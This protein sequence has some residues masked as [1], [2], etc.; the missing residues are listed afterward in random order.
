[1]TPN[2]KAFLLVR[3]YLDNHGAA[4]GKLVIYAS[5]WLVSIRVRLLF[6]LQAESSSA[7]NGATFP[8]SEA[9]MKRNAQRYT[10]KSPGASCFFSQ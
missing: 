8:H 3:L 4:S 2:N 1:M 7:C 9:T 10:S 6:A 5:V